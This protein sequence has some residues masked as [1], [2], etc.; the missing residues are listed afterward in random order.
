MEPRS[1]GIIYGDNVIQCPTEVRISRILV[2]V[3]VV[4]SA[5]L[6]LF[7][8][9]VVSVEPGNLLAFLVGAVTLQ[10]AVDPAERVANLACRA[11][12]NVGEQAKKEEGGEEAPERAGRGLQKGQKPRG[13]AGVVVDRAGA[14]TIVGC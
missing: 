8:T 12:R 5:A 11:L 6:V 2:V 10:P 7:G 4:E 1:R 3:V 9:T 13:R 14:G